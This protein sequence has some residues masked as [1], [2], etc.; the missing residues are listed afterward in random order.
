MAPR[1]LIIRAALSNPIAGDVSFGILRRRADGPLEINQT[2]EVAVKLHAS[3]HDPTPLA[4]NI[5]LT[6]DLWRNRTV[7]AFAPIAG[8]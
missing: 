2:L 6:G 7:L 4:C 8:R 5:F 1:R 3:R